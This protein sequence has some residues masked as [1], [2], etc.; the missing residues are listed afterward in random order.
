[1]KKEKERD[2]S[3]KGQRHKDT[4]EQAKRHKQVEK[5]IKI[6]EWWRGRTYREPCH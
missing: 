4:R 2:E 5:Y 1:V 3:G 6:L